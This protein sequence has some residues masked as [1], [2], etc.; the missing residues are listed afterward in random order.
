LISAALIAG[1]KKP[2]PAADAT[3]KMDRAKSAVPMDDDKRI[4]HALNRFT[5]GIRPGDVEK[6]PRH[7]PG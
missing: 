7:G 4:V 2:K 5:F 1:D 6:G 3:E